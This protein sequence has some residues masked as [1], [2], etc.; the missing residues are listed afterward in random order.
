MNMTYFKEIFALYQFLSK[1]KPFSVLFLTFCTFVIFHYDSA[2]A[3]PVPARCIVLPMQA[4]FLDS[5][6]TAALQTSIQS[7]PLYNMLAGTSREAATCRV[8]FQEEGRFEINYQFEGGSWLLF[9][10]DTRI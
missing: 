10:S 6:S 3:A 9:K 8:Q 7:N 1:V 2:F 5:V 4:S